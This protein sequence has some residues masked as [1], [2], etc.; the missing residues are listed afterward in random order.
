METH[1][2]DLYQCILLLPKFDN[3]SHSVTKDKEICQSHMIMK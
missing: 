2:M 3:I 1:A